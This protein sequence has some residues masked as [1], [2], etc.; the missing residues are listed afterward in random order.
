MLVLASA[1]HPD[2][3]PGYKGGVGLSLTPRH[4]AWVQGWCWPQPHTQTWGLGTRVVLASASHPDMGPGYKGG[5][6][7]SLTPRHG[8]WVL[9]SASHPD[10]GPGYE[11]SVGLRQKVVKSNFTTFSKTFIQA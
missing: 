9:A 8:A 3:G 10:M 2:M 6:G 11:T 7:L 1:L 4:G 5:V